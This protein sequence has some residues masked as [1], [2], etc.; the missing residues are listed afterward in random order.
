MNDDDIPLIVKIGMIVIVCFILYVTIRYNLGLF[1][2]L[3]IKLK[4]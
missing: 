3:N 4:I 2:F 1:E